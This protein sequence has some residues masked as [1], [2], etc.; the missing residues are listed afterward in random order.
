[1]GE[2]NYYIDSEGN[3]AKGM[4]LTPVSIEVINKESGK[5]EIKWIYVDKLGKRVIHQLYDHAS[6]F[7]GYGFAMVRLDQG[8]NELY[9]FIDQTG[10]AVV[11]I[12]YD[13]IFPFNDFGYTKVKKNNMW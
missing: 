6:P 11:P 9:G 7:N 4:G 10:K 8:K 1:M 2:K 13:L 12:I 3:A 5:K